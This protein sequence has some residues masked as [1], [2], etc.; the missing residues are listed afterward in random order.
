MNYF[1]KIIF[2][3][4]AFFITFL[5][6]CSSKFETAYIDGCIKEG[7]YSSERCKCVASLLDKTLSEGQ[8]KMV[9][10]PGDINNL[11]NAMDLMKSSL[12]ALEKCQLSGT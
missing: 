2:I 8:K 1:Y 12:N 7:Q 6:G 3:C 4:S 11:S 9:L 10:H 5:Q